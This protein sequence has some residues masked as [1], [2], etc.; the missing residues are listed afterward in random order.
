MPEPR[1]AP[2]AELARLSPLLAPEIAP[3]APTAPFPRQQPQLH[4]RRALPAPSKTPLDPPRAPTAL[5]ATTHQ[6]LVPPLA[7]HAALA[8]FPL[9]AKIPA[10]AALQVLSRTRLPELSASRV[11]LESSRRTR[12]IQAARAAQGAPTRV[13]GRP[14]A[15]TAL[16]ER[17]P[18]G[19][20]APLSCARRVFTS[21]PQTLA[22]LAVLAATPAAE[23]PR[24][25]LRAPPVL[26]RL[27]RAL[28]RA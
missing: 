26:S 11:L 10:L 27:R 28:P 18:T 12:A 19:R 21:T 13:R 16:R 15:P 8:L 22:R 17:S 9:R 2:A 6:T 23:R 3:P 24:R 4:A 5:Q 1:A 7:R 14:L 20:A 25:A